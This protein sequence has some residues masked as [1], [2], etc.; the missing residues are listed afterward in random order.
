MSDI[1]TIMQR[2]DE[3]R[4]AENEGIK[5][6]AVSPAPAPSA[7]ALR[8]ALQSVLS[9]EKTASAPAPAATESPVDGMLKLAEDLTN[10]EEEAMLKQAAVYGAAMCDGF[11]NRFSQ[12][13]QAAM[14]T[15]T[16]KHAA[17]LPSPQQHDD[18]LEQIKTA[19]ASPDFAKFAE[20]NPDMVKEAFDLG[21]RSQMDELIKTAQNDFD[22]GYQDAMNEVHKVA[23]TCY[24]QGAHIINDVIRS[25]QQ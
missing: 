6:A 10:A 9:T 20:A 12:Y 21:Y 18:M 23:S 7:D 5:T 1:A 15:D 19:A 22:Q 4:Q 24:A 17:A 25:V 3:S 2:L 14:A 13:E 16:T 11:M 8:S